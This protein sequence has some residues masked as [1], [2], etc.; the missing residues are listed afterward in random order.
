MVGTAVWTVVER[1]FVSEMVEPLA[2]CGGT[3]DST[4]LRLLFG[5]VPSDHVLLI[6]VIV[7][8]L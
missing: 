2:G 1:P 5:H 4:W 7:R 3:E 8:V 6:V